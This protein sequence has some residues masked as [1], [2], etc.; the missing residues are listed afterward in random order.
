[1]LGRGHDYLDVRVD[2]RNG[3]LAPSMTLRLGLSVD[4]RVNR[5][6]DVGAPALL[7]TS[8]DVQAGQMI[9]FDGAIASDGND[10][11]LDI[12]ILIQRTPTPSTG[13]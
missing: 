7:A 12:S 10:V 6:T 1:M 4:T 8:A 5:I 2:A 13:P 9:A 11:A 3:G